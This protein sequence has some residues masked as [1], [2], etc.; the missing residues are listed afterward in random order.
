MNPEK[1]RRIILLCLPIAAL[2]LW[3]SQFTPSLKQEPKVPVIGIP[4]TTTPEYAEAIRKAGGHPILLPYNLDDIEKHITQLDGVLFPGGA[5]ID[6]AVYGEE[7]HPTVKIVAQDRYDF[8]SKLARAWLD[9]TEKPFLGVCLGCQLLNVV[10][11][12]NLVQDIPSKFGTSHR[13]AHSIA[14]AP[15]SKLL[16]IFEAENI[17]VNSNHHQAVNQ[18]GKGLKVTAR[19]PEGVVEAIESIDG[20]FIVGVQWHPEQMPDPQQAQL[21]SQFIEAARAAMPEKQRF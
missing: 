2:G 16:G 15:E 1:L 14:I 9:R 6:P 5:D 19:S 18:L 21:F 11:G 13:Q 12:G 17:E 10:Q 7:K 4:Q 3:L 20:R 8:E